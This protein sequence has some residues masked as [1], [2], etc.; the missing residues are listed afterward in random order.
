MGV[1]GR[2]PK[3]AYVRQR[4]YPHRMTANDSQDVVHAGDAFIR[5]NLECLN[6]PA[7]EACFEH[8][9]IIIPAGE[10]TKV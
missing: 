9:S 4:P 8:F 3:F 2:S 1:R 10:P 7:K 6:Y 5:D